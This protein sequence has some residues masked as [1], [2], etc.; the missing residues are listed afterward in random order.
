M[1]FTFSEKWY[2]IQIERER[3][4]GRTGGSGSSVRQVKGA[5]M[6]KTWENWNLVAQQIIDWLSEDDMRTLLHSVLVQQYESVPELFEEDVNTLKT[7][8]I[9]PRPLRSAYNILRE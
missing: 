8:L 5:I 6:D 7:H 2:I 3:N 4:D 9:P 1:S